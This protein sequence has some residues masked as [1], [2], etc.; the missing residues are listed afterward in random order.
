[1]RAWFKQNFSVKLI[2]ALTGIVLVLAILL[3][4]VLFPSQDLPSQSASATPSFSLS[5]LANRTFPQN[6]ETYFIDRL[7]GSTFGKQAVNKLKLFSGIEEIE[8]AFRLQNRF[9]EKLTP[10]KVTM[11][12]NIASLADYQRTYRDSQIYLALIPGAAEI[13]KEDLPASPD[14]VNQT[15]LIQDIYQYFPNTQ[16]IDLISNLTARKNQYIYFRNDPL[17]TSRGAYAAY[18]SVIKSLGQTPYAE[19]MFNIEHLSHDA[20]G[21]FAQATALYD[22]DPDTVDLYHYVKGDTISQVT[23]ITRS[24]KT[25]SSELFYRDRTDPKEI[26]TSK[27]CGMIEIKTNTANGESLLL[28][29]DSFAYPMLP[30]LALHYERIVFV[31]LDH[32]TDNQYDLIAPS[33]FKN[34]LF[35]YSLKQLTTDNNIFTKLPYIGGNNDRP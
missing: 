34:Q 17:W 8:G 18:S 19:E 4:T 9:V 29:G 11:Q 7:Y 32:I 16:T 5:S 24:S 2:P 13:Y 26:F 25:V 31:D 28:Y 35:L 3:F 33:A 14:I 27:N 20:Y 15:E 6:F 1:M 10:N 12:K 30:F 21:E 22:F 23:K